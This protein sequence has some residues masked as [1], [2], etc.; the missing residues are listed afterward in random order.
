MKKALIV[1]DYQKDFVNGSLGF[2][3][4]ETL[5]EAI[6]A[7]IREYRSSGGDIIVTLDT[8]AENYLE[9]QEGKNLPV[10]HCVR[11]TGGWDLF[12]ETAKQIRET[13]RNFE[14]G[15]FGSLALAEYLK[16]QGYEQ[17][18]LVGVVSNICVISNAVL[19]KAALPESL[20]VVD[21]ACTGSSDDAMNEKALD[22]MD[23][24]QIKI[25]NRR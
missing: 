7:K 14:K 16:E 21:A 4:A 20:I 19:A 12:G 24:L 8:H 13:D 22:V 6:A 25:I 5:D 10:V 17:V 23:G 11:G 2:P 1:V 3:K 18:E 9:T 15:T